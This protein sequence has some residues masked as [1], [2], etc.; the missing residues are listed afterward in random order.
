M[1]TIDFQHPQRQPVIG[2]VLLAM[3]AGLL[4]ASWIYRES[5]TRDQRSAEQVRAEQAA[6]LQREAELRRPAPAPRTPAQIAL[7]SISP[8]LRQPWLPVLKTIE[9]V[10]EPP[11]F[12]L[13]ISIDPASGVVRIEGEAPTF[14]AAVAYVSS[15]GEPEVLQPAQLRSHDSAVDPNT[16]QPLVRFSAQAKWVTR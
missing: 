9:G 15:L 10:S 1:R 11:I 7:A 5:V 14:E 2:W 12:L 3:G 6:A 8:T 16:N 4:V 13:S